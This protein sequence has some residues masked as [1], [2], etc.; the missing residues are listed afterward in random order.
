MILLFLKTSINYNIV[1][2]AE[3]VD[4]GEDHI[5]LLFIHCLEYWH[6]QFIF[7]VGA[8]QVL[9]P[10]PTQPP[11][12]CSLMMD[13]KIAYRSFKKELFEEV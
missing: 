3:G 7:N 6:L 8:S 5:F 9:N 1:L 2:T 10:S 12:L 4:G 11:L 13:G